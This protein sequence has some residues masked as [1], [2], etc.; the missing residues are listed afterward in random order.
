MN[1]NGEAVYKPNVY[2][3][4][5]LI[6]AKY[7]PKFKEQA[8]LLIKR[9]FK[10]VDVSRNTIPNELIEFASLTEPNNLLKL[11][12]V[13]GGDPQQHNNKGI[14]GLRISGAQNVKLRNV[15]IEDLLNESKF[16]T[17][18]CGNYRFTT[19]LK[20]TSPGYLGC[21]V[22]GI[23]IENSK[24]ISLEK[25]VVIKNIFSINGQ[26]IGLDSMGNS[27]IKGNYYIKMVNSKKCH[28]KGN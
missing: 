19:S 2:A 5:Q 16:G 8:Q 6:I 21:D 7:A 23:T 28:Q 27:E 11:K 26:A 24:K 18:I 20:N 9:G 13:C 3:N 1:D 14:V 17:K 10:D 15:S 22:R 25:S 4:V 12:F